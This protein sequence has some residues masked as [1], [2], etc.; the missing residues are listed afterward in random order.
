MREKIRE[1][2]EKVRSKVLNGGRK[3]LMICIAAGLVGMLLML[4]PFG[5]DRADTQ[6]STEQ[7][8]NDCDSFCAE[9]EKRLCEL[10]GEINGVGDVRVM[11]TVD[12]TGEYVYAESENTSEGRREQ[13]YVILKKGSAEEALVKNVLSPR[14]TGV[15]V[16]CEGG[17]RDKVREEVYNTVS[18]VLGISSGRIYVAQMK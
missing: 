1:W 17:G 11:I 2:T 4:F 3:S 18:A 12:S 5:S 16:V 10:L 15:V 14:I 7:P 6:D 9:T 13:D 8:V